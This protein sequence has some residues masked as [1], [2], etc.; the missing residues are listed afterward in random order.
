MR[1]IGAVAVPLLLTLFAA[2]IV[3]Q[4]ALGIEAPRRIP[5][6]GSNASVVAGDFDGDGDDDLVVSDFTT[7]Q[8]WLLPHASRSITVV[9]IAGGL[10]FPAGAVDIDGDGRSEA[11]ML[12]QMSVVFVAIAGDGTWHEL[13]H[14]D[15][16]GFPRS[17]VM[18]RFTSQRLQFAMIDLGGSAATRLEIRDA[19]TMAVARTF[20]L[21]EGSEAY[22]LAAGD[23]NGDGMDDLVVTD[24]GHPT[25]LPHDFYTRLDGNIAAIVSNRASAAAIET[26]YQT[27]SGLFRPVLGDFDGDGRLDLAVAVQESP[28]E[29]LV[30]HGDGRGGF[31][32]SRSVPW[33]IQPQLPAAHT[34]VDIDG[35]GRDDI[36]SANG[37][38]VLLAFGTR[39]GWRTA[40]L[41][42]DVSGAVPVRSRGDRA[43]S[44]VTFGGSGVLVLPPACVRGRSVGR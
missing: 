43:P 13:R 21:P 19:E 16:E 5:L 28:G 37:R 3:A 35:D 1:R 36:V 33:S 39:D 6:N 4:C 20:A 25:G 24:E 23:L 31:A 2:P 40:Q 18:G 12:R 17:V 9:P 41:G 10:G 32:P 34:A 8:S 26:V 15:T 14:L 44:L 7:G 42:A 38:A 11:V 29:L 27:H 22:V 30:F